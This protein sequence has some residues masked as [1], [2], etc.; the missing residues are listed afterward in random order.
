MLYD[1]PSLENT[2]EVSYVP[3]YPSVPDQSEQP[4]VYNDISEC[5]AL[6]SSSWSCSRLKGLVES[7]DFLPF[8]HS[9]YRMVNSPGRSAIIIP[10][11][12]N[13]DRRPTLAGFLVHLRK[14][15]QGV[16]L[17]Y[18]LYYGPGRKA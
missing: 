6:S 13:G 2:Q 17:P 3:D 16:S 7:K 8:V 1:R 14:V 5:T 18:N 10:Y 15:D 9:N 4:I 11:F 12:N